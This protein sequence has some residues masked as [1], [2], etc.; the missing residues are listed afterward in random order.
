MP[1]PDPEPERV[2]AA[3]VRAQPQLSPRRG[4]DYRPRDGRDLGNGPAAGW[5]PAAPRHRI[6]RD[7]RRHRPGRRLHGRADGFRQN[8]SVM[9][10]GEPLLGRDLAARAG[11]PPD[12]AAIKDRRRAIVTP[13]LPADLAL[14][15]AARPR[16]DAR[17]WAGFSPCAFT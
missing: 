2:D 15:C 13:R 14:D 5:K 1:G 10:R 8:R 6:D 12:A 9:V 3:S 17:G 7:L 16:A 11:R 4:G